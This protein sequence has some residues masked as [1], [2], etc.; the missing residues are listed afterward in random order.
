VQFQTRLEMSKRSAYFQLMF[1]F[2]SLSSCGLFNDNTRGKAV[3]LNSS[4]IAVIPFDTIQNL[5]IVEAEINGFKGKFLFDNGFTLSAIDPDFAKKCGITFDASARVRDI[6]N[7]SATLPET[8]V[9]SIKIGDFDFRNTG[10]Y[11]IETKNFFPCDDVDGVIGGSIINKAN[12]KVRYRDKRIEV[13]GKKF[14]TPENSAVLDVGY[15]RGNAALTELTINEKTFFFKID[16]GMSGETSIG[17]NHVTLFRGKKGIAIEGVT[18]LGATGI[19]TVENNYELVDRQSFYY[20]E[21]VL[22]VKAVIELDESQKYAGYIGVGYLK[23]YDFILNATKKEYILSNPVIPVD[24]EPKGYGLNLYYTDDTLRIISKNPADSLLTGIPVMTEV[25]H[26]DSKPAGD[27]ES[28]CELREY[29][30]EKVK[31]KTDLVLQLQGRE[32][33]LILPYRNDEWMYIT[34]E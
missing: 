32:A 2:I 6:N 29:L 5:I 11:A 8:T 34:E 19:G 7:K 15:N 30:R 1:L 14:E 18:S 31:K 12:W 9:K 23:H 21:K 10:F 13:S 25:T 4:E 27:F 3:D 26:V 24:K 16:T 33:L 17:K 28:V 22:P 20:D